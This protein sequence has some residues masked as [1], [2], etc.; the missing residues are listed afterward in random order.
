MTLKRTEIRT[1]RLD[2]IKNNEKRNV[3]NTETGDEKDIR[4]N[5][6]EMRYTLNEGIDRIESKES[7]DTRKRMVKDRKLLRNGEKGIIN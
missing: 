1:A 6:H 4:E 2:E 5:R 3:K 7:R